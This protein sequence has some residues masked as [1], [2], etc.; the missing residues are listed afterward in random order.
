MLYKSYIPTR[1]PKYVNFDAI[2]IGHIKDI[3]YDSEGN[4]GMPVS[5]IHKFNSGQ[6][7]L[8][9]SS[10]VNLSGFNA[11]VAFVKET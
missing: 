2:E 4:M 3:L 10:L 5:F 7:E 11:R 8:V 1:Y 6:F 9:G